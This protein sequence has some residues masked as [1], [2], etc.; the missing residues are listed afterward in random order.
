MVKKLS[1]KGAFVNKGFT[2]IELMIVIAIIAFL[3]MIGIPSYMRFVCKSKRTEVYL[4]LGALYAAEKAHWAEY[5]TYSNK[6]SGSKGVGWAP[7]GEYQYTYGFAGTPGVNCVEGKL[8]ASHGN[9]SGI[10]SAS[11]NGFVA[12]AV[13]DID[14]DGKMDIITIDDKHII[15]IVQDDLN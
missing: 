15:K 9:L 7:E 2:L 14:G 3:S 13:A 8:C 1:K 11:R 5:G 10:T 6:L 12:A 4:N